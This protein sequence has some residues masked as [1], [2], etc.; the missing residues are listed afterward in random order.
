MQSV[1]L[2]RIQGVASLPFPTTTAIAVAGAEPKLAEYVEIGDAFSRS[3][4]S[5]NWWMML[6]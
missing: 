6:I 2:C 5:Y 4:L 1:D 3:R